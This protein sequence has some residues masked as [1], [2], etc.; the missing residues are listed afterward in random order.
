[1]RGSTVHACILLL[2]IP[3]VYM[4]MYCMFRID[5][6]LVLCAKSFYSIVMYRYIGIYVVSCMYNVCLAVH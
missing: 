3:H 6:A 4:Y 5:T 2:M 1:M